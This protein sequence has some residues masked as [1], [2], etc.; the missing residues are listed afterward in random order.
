MSELSSSS[1]EVG[2][3]SY[4]GQQRSH[5]IGVGKNQLSSNRAI[6]RKK[7]QRRPTTA[8][9]ACPAEPLSIHPTACEIMQ[10]KSAKQTGASAAG[11]LAPPGV[12]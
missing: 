6:G 4:E 1:D 2:S 10:Q 5:R 3:S 7:K 9:N 12:R 8:G 11:T